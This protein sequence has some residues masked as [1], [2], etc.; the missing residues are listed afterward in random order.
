V[1]GS[2]GSLGA[3]G[4]PGVAVTFDTFKNGT[5]V[6]ANF[7]GVAKTGSGLAYNTTS[8][9]IPTL[10]N[11]THRVDISVTAGRLTVAIDG[12]EK[13]SSTLALPP[14]AYVGFTAATGGLTDRHMI[15]SATISA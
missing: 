2:A 3:A 9:N 4:I 7:I 11:S 13:L 1:G 15:T 10:R 6:S 5:D 12:V 8:T 14:S